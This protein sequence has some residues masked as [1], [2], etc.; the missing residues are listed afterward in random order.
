[1]RGLI[2]GIGGFAGGHLAHA[3]VERGDR[4]AGIDRHFGPQ[5]ASISDNIVLAEGDIREADDIREL[6]AEFR[7][8]TIFHLA[9]M[10]H[11]GAAWKN[12]RETLEV[13]VIGTSA[14][15]E[16]A[17]ELEPKPRVVLASTGQV[18]GLAPEDSHALTE[19]AP[20]NPR[21]PYAVSKA[22]C[23][24]LARQA[25]TGEGVPTVIL[26]TFNY[27]GPWQS[28]QFVCSDFARQVAWIEAGLAEAKMKVGNLQTRRDFSDVRD[29]IDAYLL[30]AEHGAPG[31]AYNLA[32]GDAVVI[33]DVLER[34]RD[35]VD[36]DIEVKQDAGRVREIDLAALVGDAAR[37]REELGWKPRFHF[38]ETLASVLDF[39]R[40]QAAKEK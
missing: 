16:V 22:C 2:T 30:A 29:I 25:W 6:A 3:L 40:R 12:R 31:E 4:V 18:Y 33:A 8:D 32:S 1:M 7:P 13:N 23:E 10:T 17:A 27:T 21:S 19:E 24:L 28:P 39:W 11:V 5:L 38:D 37:A 34:L 35:A 15:L 14:V 20:L 9:A 36:I 26:R